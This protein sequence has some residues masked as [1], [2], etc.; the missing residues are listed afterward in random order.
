MGTS[1]YLNSFRGFGGLHFANVTFGDRMQNVTFA[2]GYAYMKTGN[3]QFTYTEGIYYRE[4]LFN[5]VPYESGAGP[6]VRG[7][8]FSVAGIAKV[9]TKASFVFDSNTVLT[10]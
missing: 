9:G 5:T 1:G 8:I 7:P 10:I 6:L 4:Y 3:R 2:A